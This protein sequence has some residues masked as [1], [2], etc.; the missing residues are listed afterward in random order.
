MTRRPAILLTAA[1]AALLAACAPTTSTTTIRPAIQPPLTAA[2]HYHPFE[3]GTSL[4]YL[5]AQGN[6]YQL[7]TLA[8][9]LLSGRATQHQRYEGPGITRSTYRIDSPQGLLLIRTDD[10]ERITTYD[11]PVLELP[12]AGRLEVGL[13][14]GGDTL[15]RTYASP[16]ANEPDTTTPLSYLA[17]V[18]DIQNMRIGNERV[19]VFLISAEEYRMVG[20]ATVQSSHERWYAPYYGDVTNREEHNLAQAR[21]R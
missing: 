6:E 3:P 7:T 13:R 14:W 1:L 20:E 11:P 5:D 4:T 12:A 10:Q 18:T 17:E 15:E 2:E 21:T 19:T 8:P 9:R 16:T